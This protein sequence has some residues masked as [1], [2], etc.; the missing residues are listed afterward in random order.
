VTEAHRHV[1]GPP[2]AADR[3]ALPKLSARSCD[4]VVE[5]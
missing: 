4:Y 5:R 3:K 2:V 1:R